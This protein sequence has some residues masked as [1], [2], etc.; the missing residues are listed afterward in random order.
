MSK[1][2]TF[3]IIIPVRQINDYVTETLSYLKA[4]SFKSFEVLVITDKISRS[5]NPAIKRNLGAKMAK[6][7][8]LAF[9]DDDSYP[10]NDWLKNAKKYLECDPKIA[11]VCGPCLTPP[12]DNYLQQANGLIWSSFLGSGGAGTY[13]NSPEK[14]RYVDDFPSVN[15]IVK[16]DTFDKV[17]GFKTK[18]WPGEDT[19]LCLSIVNYRQSKIYYHPSILVYHHRRPLL[20]PHLKQV[21][22]YAFHRGNFARKFPQ[23]SFRIGYLIP[24]AFAIYI[25]SLLPCLLLFP[26]IISIFIT[27]L[28]LYTFLLFFTFVSF[29]RAN[30]FST[31]LLASLSIPITHFYYGILFI[32]GFFK[33]DLHYIP[34][35]VDLATGKYQGG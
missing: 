10:S 31:S 17:G 33:K 23:T 3:S 21:G 1:K 26:Q 24:S 13:R 18:Y 22:R 25:I 12:A 7:K 19:L 14:A 16:K 4:Q 8:H 29:S 35:K 6:G 5:P 28:I 34:K 9:L 15:L 30:P 32:V 2:P 20:K 27:P 11:A